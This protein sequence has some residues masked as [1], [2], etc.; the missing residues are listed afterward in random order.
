MPWGS[1]EIVEEARF[2]GEYHVPAI[3]LLRYTDGDAAGSVSIRFC[4]YSH[5]G[6]FQR[7]PLMLGEEEIDGLRE[8]LAEAPQLRELL[9]R[10]V[11]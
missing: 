4:Y 5:Q 10:L 9:R 7:G 3:Q 1:G 11:R 8:A 6:R 2:A